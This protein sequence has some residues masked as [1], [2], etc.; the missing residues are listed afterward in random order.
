M[1]FMVTIFRSVK[2]HSETNPSIFKKAGP[3]I[4]LLY[5]MNCRERS[6]REIIFEN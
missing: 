4:T 6:F 2:A 5:A 1:I 3:V